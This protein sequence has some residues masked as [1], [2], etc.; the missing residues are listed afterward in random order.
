MSNDPQKRYRS[1][2][3]GKATKRA[4]DSLPRVLEKKRA[5]RK[6][7]GPT[8]RLERLYGITL[9]ERNAM[10]Q[11]QGGMCALCGK[12]RKLVVDHDHTTGR[13]RALLCVWC[14]AFVGIVEK[15]APQVPL[16]QAYLKEM[17]YV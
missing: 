9:E 6:T 7:F 12:K 17:S 13:V 10:A 15:Y 11:R 5:W 1:S 8:R 3:K 16:A 14:N 2:P 4:Y